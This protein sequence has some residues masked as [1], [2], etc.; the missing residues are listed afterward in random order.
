MPS[1]SVDLSR[2]CSH[3]T[4]FAEPIRAQMCT[5]GL[6]R[7]MTAKGYIVPNDCPLLGVKRTL[8]IAAHASAF[9]PKRATTVSSLTTVRIPGSI[10][11][12]TPPGGL[13]DM[14]KARLKLMLDG[15]SQNTRPHHRPARGEPRWRLRRHDR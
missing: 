13:K 14:A 9:D 12:V 8:A 1:R 4:A 15:Q 3:G 6:L 10:R 7:R 5:Q 2:S 11:I